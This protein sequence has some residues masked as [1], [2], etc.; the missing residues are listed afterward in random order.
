[1]CRDTYYYL[2][3]LDCFSTAGHRDCLSKRVSVSVN[4]SADQTQWGRGFFP[5]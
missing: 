3:S 5:G 1:M 2:D 4:V